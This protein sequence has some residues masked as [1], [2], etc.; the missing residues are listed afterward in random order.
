MRIFHCLL[1]GALLLYVPVNAQ[2]VFEVDGLCYKVLTEADEATTFGTAEVVPRENGFYEGTVNIPNGVKSSKGQYAD[3]YKVVAIAEKAFQNC[4]SLEKVT[5]PASVES[6]GQNA[7]AGC[8]S[9][10]TVIFA[11]GNLRTMGRE[12]FKDSGIKH[13]EI[14]EGITDLPWIAF[15]GCKNLTDVVLP[16]TLR[17]IGCSAFAQC[18]SLREVKLPDGLREIMLGCFWGSGIEKIKLPSMI[19]IV[20]NTFCQGCSNLKE[21][22]LSP[23]TMKIESNAFMGCTSLEKILLPEKL[24]TIEGMAF[25]QCKSL[26]NI[27]LPEN[28]LLIGTGAFDE[29]SSLKSI[30]FPKNLKQIESGAFRD[31]I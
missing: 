21:V 7:F 10:E 3:T 29:C 17:T 24:K 22:E 23:N 15:F 30:A 5:V 16:T 18:T 27:V 26:D 1:L 28:L 8:V 31:C 20:P 25:C 4:M 2:S 11:K 14:P 12:V 19:T 6:I 13:I 9:L